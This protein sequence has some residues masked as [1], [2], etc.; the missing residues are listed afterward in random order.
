MRYAAA[1]L[2]IAA[3]PFAYGELYSGP[4]DG[5]APYDTA[6]GQG[7]AVWADHSYD[8][9]PQDPPRNN[10]P[11]ERSLY[12]GDVVRG[13]YAWGQTGCCRIQTS[14]GSSGAWSHAEGPADS[15][16][17]HM[18]IIPNEPVPGS[19]TYGGYLQ[20]A[21]Y[22]GDGRSRIHRQG[23]T[24]GHG[25]T[26]GT[27]FTIQGYVKADPSSPCN[28]LAASV[29][30]HSDFR[31]R[32]PF[33]ETSIFEHHILA[34]D[35]FPA[36]NLDYTQYTFDAIP[37]E[38]GSNL[39]LGGYRWET[40]R[41]TH[42][43][44]GGRIASEFHCI[45]KTCRIGL[46]AA[47]ADHA[48]VG[49]A[50]YAG[51]A[52]NPPWEGPKGGA[53]R[54]L[55]DG[56]AV[57]SVAA[58][59][60]GQINII[61]TMRNADRE[62]A[63]GYNATYQFV[64]SYGP[65][66]HAAA[67]TNTAVTADSALERPVSVIMRYNGTISDT[68]HYCSAGAAY[69]RDGSPVP[70]GEYGGPDAWGRLAGAPCPE[71]RPADQ[72]GVS[73]GDCGGGP[74]TYTAHPER[75]ASFGWGRWSAVNPE[76]RAALDGFEG[77]H[78]VCE[79]GAC[80]AHST[81]YLNWDHAPATDRQFIPACTMAR[82]AA[83]GGPHT[84]APKP[85]NWG[86]SGDWGFGETFG[87]GEGASP[88]SYRGLF[89]AHS[90]PRHHVIDAAQCEHALGERECVPRGGECRPEY[91]RRCEDV[92]T[93]YLYPDDYIIRGHQRL[94]G[95]VAEWCGRTPTAECVLEAHRTID[96]VL[97]ELCSEYH[98]VDYGGRGQRVDTSVLSGSGFTPAACH[99]AYS[100][101]LYAPAA[102]GRIVQDWRACYGAV[103]EPSNP[104][105]VWPDGWPDS[106]PRLCG[107]V[108]GGS[109]IYT[110]AWEG[111]GRLVYV[112]YT[113]AAG[114]FGGVVERPGSML[115]GDG[116]LTCSCDDADGNNICDVAENGTDL[117]GNGIA[118]D[119]DSLLRDG[120]RVC[121]DR[122]GRAAAEVAACWAKYGRDRAASD[123][124]SGRLAACL[125]DVG[126]DGPDG[127]CDPALIVGAITPD[128][129]VDV[130]GLD[131]G[132]SLEDVVRDVPPVPFLGTDGVI[133]IPYV[134]DGSHA[135][136]DESEAWCISSGDTYQAHAPRR[137]CENRDAPPSTKRIPAPAT[138]PPLY[139]PAFDRAWPPD[140]LPPYPVGDWE[141][142]EH[143]VSLDRADAEAQWPTAPPDS[144][145][146]TP[147]L[148]GI[149]GRAMF[150]HAG[151]G[152]VRFGP[153]ADCDPGP[154]ADGGW[155]GTIRTELGGASHAWEP[156]MR[157]PPFAAGQKAVARAVAVEP[158]ASCEGGWR[159]GTGT[160]GIALTITAYPEVQRPV[161][162]AAEMAAH[163]CQIDG[164]G[165]AG[166]LNP[167]TEPYRDLWHEMS[168]RDGPGIS[169]TIQDYEAAKHGPAA[170]REAGQPWT[171]AAGVNDVSTEIFRNGVWLHT[172]AIL[173]HRG[174][175]TKYDWSPDVTPGHTGCPAAHADACGYDGGC[176]ADAPRICEGVFVE[177]GI[178]KKWT[179]TE[180]EMRLAPAAGVC[181]TAGCA[182]PC[183]DRLECIGRCGADMEC[184][185]ECG[186]MDGC[187]ATHADGRPMRYTDCVGPCHPGGVPV[188]HRLPDGS[189][190]EGGA[191][192]D[193]AT[194]AWRQP[195]PVVSG[196]EAA[197]GADGVV[198]AVLRDIP[199]GE[200][201]F[202]A[203]GSFACK[204]VA[205]CDR[206]TVTYKC[207][208]GEL[209][210]HITCDVPAESYSVLDMPYEEVLGSAGPQMIHIE[211]VCP[212]DHR[213]AGRAPGCDG[214]PIYDTH[215]LSEASSGATVYVDYYGVGELD[216][217]REGAT[218]RLLPPPTFG[219]VHGITVDG[220]PVHVA[221]CTA[222]SIVHAAAADVAAT[223]LYGAVL[224]AEV[225]A[226]APPHTAI[227]QADEMAAA[228]W[229]YLPALA[230]LAAA[231]LALKK[232]KLS[233]G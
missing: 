31:Y 76:T 97:V 117:D 101:G 233:D 116:A 28:T 207:L 206:Q 67:M 135:Y 185:A 171:V 21:T 141:R 188:V 85:E 123:D 79:N 58:A 208:G 12:P 5:S 26:A 197:V 48:Y 44:E 36:S 102:G 150:M 175:C 7:C 68:T 87:V 134:V 221:P 100:V 160:P 103:P 161:A 126:A 118:D 198:P 84:N 73:G 70:A 11:H 72:W 91:D 4:D 153:C 201:N 222:C 80:T 210:Q 168:C 75:P 33:W 107:P 183:P 45:G 149:D 214:E 173:E 92:F 34:P 77:A 217:V 130:S 65:V 179:F 19:E 146:R 61:S 132:R 108:F 192:V 42:G 163:R 46:P 218:I 59:Q 159:P 27:S 64:P 164:D 1:L 182:P 216:A 57:F 158:C 90:M 120:D 86:M 177:D 157:H 24:E 38:A 81:P 202:N 119:W 74:C 165:G 224:T 156:S 178:H 148:V 18:K 169:I 203:G 125:A 220:R 69:D 136:C 189:Y 162:G 187:P 167:D 39:I 78:T 16:M 29:T 170:K 194:L 60:S 151:T 111:E 71:E 152:V 14:F 155:S 89:A 110:P 226:A 106:G 54:L 35:G 17:Q 228:A 200:M 2:A 137:V 82:L 10:A 131:S 211:A 184:A 112:P 40:I 174:Q 99:A 227:L 105:A 52:R 190:M 180:A 231:W 219:A 133:P 104:P 147:S 98:G 142:P 93:P 186:D 55:D 172:T 15:Y 204:E 230:A 140:C 37:L 3:M 166:M 20:T 83:D 109:A 88:H 43:L 122:T 8:W 13:G 191:A 32:N 51:T 96:D 181:G 129:A 193:P 209:T 49:N 176:V 124:A 127:D 196:C 128:G 6:G 56:E 143:P 30:M 232:Y 121:L 62:V 66:M 25:L 144:A 113:P 50:P 63:R 114:A 41:I 139:R 229:L 225:E 213:L 53:A 47:P 205:A 154:S 199:A 22:D 195:G 115:A 23:V 95:M 94:Q 223:N 9:S 138:M 145:V 215:V 212:A